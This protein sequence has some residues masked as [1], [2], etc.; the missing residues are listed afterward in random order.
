MWKDYDGFQAALL[1]GLAL[2]LLP[3][4]RTFLGESIGMGNL[5]A[6]AFLPAALGFLLALRCGVV[7]LSVWAVMGAGGL[8][9]ARAINAFAATGPA[10]G[11][12]LPAAIGAAMLL[13]AIVG[14][15]NAVVVRRFPRLGI[16]VTAATGLATLGAARWIVS[17][18]CLSIPDDAF[19]PWVSGLNDL[20]KGPPGEDENPLDGPLLILRMLVV[21]AAWTCALL[22]LSARDSAER[23]KPR[24][25]ARR[26]ARPAALC[27]SGALAALSGAC[28][29]I[30]EGI[31]PV[32]TRLIDELTIPVAAIL[33]GAVILR[34]EGRTKLAVICLPP[35]MLLANVWELMVWPT[36]FRGYSISLAILGALALLAQR[37]FVAG[38]RYIHR[39]KIRSTK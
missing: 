18:P 31:A 14:G 30:D 4:W 13:G 15:V 20:L 26:W 9:A 37:S 11:W 2:L 35:A 33:A 6:G 19:D 34:G 25:G 1:V 22:V 27:A 17:A 16:L 39:R 36:T 5:L 24:P 23:K 10:P 12:A 21:F 28:W 29:L 38:R 7:D 32:P 8:V 3:A